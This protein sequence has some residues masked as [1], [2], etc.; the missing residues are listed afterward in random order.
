[1]IY[2]FASI[3]I[4]INAIKQ[5]EDHYPNTIEYPIGAWIVGGLLTLVLIYPMAMFIHEVNTGKLYRQDPNA[6]MLDLDQSQSAE[7]FYSSLYNLPPGYN[8]DDIWTSK[9]D[10]DPDELELNGI[11]NSS[12]QTGYREGRTK[13]SMFGRQ[14]D[15]IVFSTEI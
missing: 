8:T 14:E 6:S 12:R 15:T 10:P 7:Q 2:Y 9:D 5:L 1:M 13:L 11:H 3:I 4:E